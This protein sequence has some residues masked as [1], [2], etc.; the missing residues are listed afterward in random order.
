MRPTR[1]GVRCSGKVS[2]SPWPPPLP[3]WRDVNACA[4]PHL[5]VLHKEHV[6]RLQLAVDL[7]QLLGLWHVWQ[8]ETKIRRVSGE[9][10]LLLPA[11]IPA[12]PPPPR[13]QRRRGAGACFPPRSVAPS[14]LRRARLRLGLAPV[15]AITLGSVLGPP[16]AALA[17]PGPLAAR[18]NAWMGPPHP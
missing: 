18:A 4:P 9:R 14:K 8:R 15:I 11:P 1:V 16:P 2:A 5:A 3:L 12:S 10:P 13:L 6:G 17:A 7:Q